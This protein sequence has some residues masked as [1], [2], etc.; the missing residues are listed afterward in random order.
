MKQTVSVSVLLSMIIFFGNCN[1]NTQNASTEKYVC[2]PCGH[3]CDAVV[4][5]APGTCEHCKMEM[6]KQS[7]IVNAN[8]L[9][10]DL[11][12]FILK[13]G[14]DSVLLLDV[15]TAEEFNGTAKEKFGRLKNA[16]NIPVQELKDRLKE[17]EPYKNKNIVVY[18]SHAHRSAAAAYQLTQ[19]GFTKVTNL[20]YGMHMWKDEVKDSA[21]NQN[22]YIAQ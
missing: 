9:P 4:T 13:T 15:R 6:V 7:T 20:L 16:L 14:A 19:N 17:L 12:P 11:Y 10:A 8:I 3:D 5:T 22:L 1:S 18:C 21:S 2:I